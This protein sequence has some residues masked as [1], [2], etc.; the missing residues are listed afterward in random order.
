M[1]FLG[2]CTPHS[3]VPNTFILLTEYHYV[4]QI[5][6]KILKFLTQLPAYEIPTVQHHSKL[7]VSSLNSNYYLSCHNSCK[8][9]IKDKHKII[10]EII[11]MYL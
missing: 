7:K 1:S 9:D 10:L 8:A 6:L 3:L 5:H 4:L 2:Q 11:G